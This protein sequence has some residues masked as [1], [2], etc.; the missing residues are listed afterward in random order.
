MNES[1]SLLLD[2]LVEDF[3]R[4][5]V[6]NITKSI[7]VDDNL[8]EAIFKSLNKH[9]FNSSLKPI[10]VKYLSFNNILIELKRRKSMQLPDNK[11]LGVYSVILENDIDK[12]N[13]VDKLIL[14][15]DTILMN[16]DNLN[17]RTFIFNVASICHEMIHYFDKEYGEY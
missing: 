17:N 13:L 5:V 14:H 6:F 9:F 10:D 11:L 2:K 16:K 3:G 12:I 4:S 7:V 8:A 1:T 15:D